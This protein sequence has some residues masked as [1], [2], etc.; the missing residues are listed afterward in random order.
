MPVGLMPA[1]VTSEASLNVPAWTLPV[2][3]VPSTPHLANIWPASE[4]HSQSMNC[5]MA[6]K[7]WL[8]RAF[9]RTT[10]PFSSRLPAFTAPRGPIGTGIFTMVAPGIEARFCR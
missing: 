2:Y 4:Y 7:F 10:T 3:V 1:H 5:I 8:S 9:F 6:T